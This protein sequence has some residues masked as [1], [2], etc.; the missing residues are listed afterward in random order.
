MG[1]NSISGSGGKQARARGAAGGAA[2]GGVRKANQ[3]KK[4]DAAQKQWEEEQVANYQRNRSNYN[5]AYAACLE[6]RSY[7]VR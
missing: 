3:K 7:T 2:V 1:R 5:R 6:G 4:E